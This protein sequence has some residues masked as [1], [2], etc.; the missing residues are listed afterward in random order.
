MP[1]A[2]L[3]LSEV[4][5]RYATRWSLLDTLE[6]NGTVS[7]FLGFS[8]GGGAIGATLQPLALARPRR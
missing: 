3:V 6:A 1:F 7:Y 2:P 5:K 8:T 4:E